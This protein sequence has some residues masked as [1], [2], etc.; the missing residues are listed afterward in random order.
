MAPS[1]VAM[2]INE[3]L[4]GL[5][6]CLAY[7]GDVIIYS[8]SDYEHL[9]HLQQTF[10]C[11][12]KTILKLKLNQCDFFKDQ[13]HYLGH[14]LSQEGVSRFPKKPDAIKSILSPQNDKEIRQFLELAGYHRN[15]ISHYVNI[16]H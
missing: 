3:I 5:D 13:I 9:D 15:H 6:S 8:K 14:L 1:Y 11:L 10:D 7:L 12:C 4:K 2:M 16:S